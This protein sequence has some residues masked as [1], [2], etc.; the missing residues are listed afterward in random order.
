[1]NRILKFFNLVPELK[2]FTVKAQIGPDG[3]ARITT[4]FY[5]GK[6]PWNYGGGP[7]VGDTGEFQIIIVQDES[8]Y[9]QA[10]EEESK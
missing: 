8:P 1:M 6:S 3:K 10:F 5:P 9:T 4:P 7:N 2:T